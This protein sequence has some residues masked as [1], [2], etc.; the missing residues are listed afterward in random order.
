MYLMQK[1]AQASL[2]DLFGPW[3]VYILVSEGV[4]LL[5]FGILSIPYRTGTKTR[6][7]PFQTS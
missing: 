1:P 6:Q 3:P 5:L 4:A 7:L 2:L